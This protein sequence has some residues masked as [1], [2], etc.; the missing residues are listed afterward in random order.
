VYLGNRPDLVTLDVGEEHGADVAVRVLLRVESTALRVLPDHR[1]AVAPR[2]EV[3]VKVDLRRAVG[4]LVECLPVRGPRPRDPYVEQRDVLIAL[5]ASQ[6]AGGHRTRHAELVHRQSCYSDPDARMKRLRRLLYRGPGVADVL[7]L[8]SLDVGLE[9]CRY[10]LEE[11]GEV[12]R[13]GG[14]GRRNIRADDSRGRGDYSLGNPLTVSL[15]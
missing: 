2:H 7:S 15:H 6:I 4:K 1:E 9:L 14:H 12:Y 11:R 8:N 5:G 10:A 13:R 3:L